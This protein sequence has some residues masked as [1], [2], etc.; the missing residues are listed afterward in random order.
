MKLKVLL[1]VPNF[2][3]C[4][5]D[6]RSNWHFIPYN[7]CLIAATIKD[8]VTVNIIDANKNNYSENDLIEELKNVKP[9]VVGITALMDQYGPAGHFAAK[10]IKKYNKNIITIY[11]GVYAT[12][13]PE[14]V[15]K[16][17]NIDWCVIG[18]GE[19]IVKQLLLYFMGESDVP[20][21]G[22]AFEKDGKMHNSGH[23]DFISDLNLIPF[24]AYDFVDYNS[25]SHYKGSR[26]SVDS[27]PLYPYARILTSRGCPYN[28]VFC[29]VESI[30]GKQFR[31]RSA[32]NV[33]NEIKWLK[34]KYKIKSIIFDDDN[35]FTDRKRAVEIFQGMIDNKLD[36]PWLA[37]AVSAFKLD[38]ELI[39]LME[40]SGCIYINIAIESGT[41]RVLKKIIKKPINLSSAKNI[42]RIVK[43]NNIFIAANFMVGFPGET[44]DE[45]RKTLQ[46]AQE[47][48][49]DY[50]KIFTPIPLPK[51]RLWDLCEKSKSFKKGF[52]DNKAMWNSGQIETE[53]FTSRDLTILR[54]Y[55]WDRINF[56]NNEKM[57]KIALRMNISVN[58]INE[59]RKKT[60]YIA[61]HFSE[62]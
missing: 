43:Q 19:K 36:L 62:E 61:S 59:M 16:D 1:L 38:E 14:K 60:R 6:E 49:V 8:I 10:I 25:Y 47:I 42:A 46:Y 35:L 18:E 52:N 2:E 4:D 17:K 31:A 58:E 41:E 24:P 7:L 55:E 13:N 33:L 23:A 39:K 29:Q 34:E 27:P 54:A 15:V 40:K 37:I 22:I 50:V 3:W 48:D 26:K 20:K 11:G 51:T 45:I 21:R 57:E 5:W 9:D 53:E 32:E 56:S 28:C 12:M 30:S 44:W